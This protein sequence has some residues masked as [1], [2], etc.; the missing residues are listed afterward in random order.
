MNEKSASDLIKKSHKK[1]NIILIAIGV[2]F[3]IVWLPIY[4][5]DI[6]IN[7]NENLPIAISQEVFIPSLD[8]T[9]QNNELFISPNEN[10]GT[11]IRIVVKE[12]VT[13]TAILP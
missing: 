11:N 8:P 12:G 5:V 13:N 6:P 7:G 9:M 4:P 2:V 10:N 1:R 3:V